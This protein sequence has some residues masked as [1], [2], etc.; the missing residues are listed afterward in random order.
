MKSPD[1]HDQLRHEM[2][3]TGSDGFSGVPMGWEMLQIG[4]VIG[5]SDRS[6]EGMF[7]PDAAARVIS[8]LINSLWICC[9]DTRLGV[10]RLAHIGNEENVQT[11][12]QH[13]AHVIGSDGILWAVDP[14]R[15]VGARTCAFWLITCEIWAC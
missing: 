2:E 6:I 14:T 8:R 1:I 12:L 3:V 4:G 5:E 9:F 11:I 7:L 10:S 13:P 15:A